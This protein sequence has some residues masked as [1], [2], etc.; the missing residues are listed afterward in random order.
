MAKYFLSP[1]S[2]HVRKQIYRFDDLKRAAAAGVCLP[3][4]FIVGSFKWQESS[5]S[6]WYPR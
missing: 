1:P 3:T 2:G 4:I 6:R 5:G